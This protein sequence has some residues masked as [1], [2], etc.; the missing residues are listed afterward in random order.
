[1][2]R[3][4]WLTASIVRGVL[5]RLIT[6]VVDWLL[7]RSPCPPSVLPQS[8]T[9][10]NYEDRPWFHRVDRRRGHQLVEEGG[11]GCFLVRPSSKHMMTLQLWYKGRSFNIPIRQ[12]DDNQI[13][14]GTLKPNERFFPDLDELIEYY[15]TREDL[16]LFSKGVQRGTC[17]LKN[18]ARVPRQR[19]QLPILARDTSVD[20]SN[21]EY[22]GDGYIN[23]S[24]PA[25][26]C[27][28][29]V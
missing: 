13:S 14:L 6:D 10:R 21:T 20:S 19:H 3:Y 25:E 16:I 12:R 22:S 17:R 1:M 27:V 5:R 26:N 11:D 18:P 9:E 29:H 2:C 8:Q 24:L 4:L 28:L 23:F 7:F 15:K